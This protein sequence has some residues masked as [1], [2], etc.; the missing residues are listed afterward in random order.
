M[1]PLKKDIRISM[2]H[3]FIAQTSW[4]KFSNNP[5]DKKIHEKN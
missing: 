2:K 5:S 4:A 3:N 1:P